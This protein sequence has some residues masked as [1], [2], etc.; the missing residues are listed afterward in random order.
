MHEVLGLYLRCGQ[1][2]RGAAA[3]CFGFICFPGHCPPSLDCATRSVPVADPIDSCDRHR[4]VSAGHE[5]LS[6][7]SPEAGRGDLVSCLDPYLD[8]QSNC[9]EGIVPTQ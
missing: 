2:V 1:C 3:V 4:K 8:C 7:G 6:Q 9:P 5:S